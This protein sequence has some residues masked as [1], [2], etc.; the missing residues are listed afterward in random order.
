M[1]GVILA[2]GT[3]SRL[4]PLTNITNKH[5]L[6]IYD[7]PMIYYPLAK[8]KELGVKSVLIV[9]GTGHAGNFLELLGSGKEF[10]MSF[11]YEVQEQAGGIADAL[12]LARD[13]VGGES[14]VVILGDN[15]FTDDLTGVVEEFKAS[16]NLSHVF[17]TEVERPQSYGVARFEGSDPGDPSGQIVEIT[18]KPADP[19]SNYAVTGCYIYTP[20]VFEII[21]GLEPSARGELEV[22]DINDHYV[23]QGKMGH[24]LLSGFWGDCGESIDQMLDVANTMRDL[25]R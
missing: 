20:A 25:A 15:I 10:G 19:P 24:T 16:G 21:D 17:L 8:M 23:K 9:T 22:T 6:P 5:L 2:G 1:K 11:S 18:E 14:F 4:A 7:R 13:F 12:S 3:G